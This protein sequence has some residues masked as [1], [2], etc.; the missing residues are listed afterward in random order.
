M[1]GRCESLVRTG[2]K[3]IEPDRG[4]HG[5]D[6]STCPVAHYGDRNNDG[7][8]RQRS[9]RPGKV[10]P[11]RHHDGDHAERERQSRNDD[12]QV[13]MTPKRVH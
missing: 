1:S 6:E 9:G 2:E 12:Q 4:R 11:K 7:N 10:R 8:Q 5:G 3:E 13:S